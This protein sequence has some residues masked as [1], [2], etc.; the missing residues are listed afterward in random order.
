MIIFLFS[1]LED[2]TASDHLKIYMFFYSPGENFKGDFAWNKEDCND[3]EH[4]RD[5][6]CYHSPLS[7][8]PQPNMENGLGLARVSRWWSVH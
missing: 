2:Q 8:I 6:N 1:V 5:R 7:H 4:K 3:R